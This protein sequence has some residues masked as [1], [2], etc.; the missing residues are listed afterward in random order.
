MKLRSPAVE[1]RNSK[2]RVCARSVADHRWYAVQGI[3]KTLDSI[4]GSRKRA[5]A[6]NMICMDLFARI[7]RDLNDNPGTS[8][9][10]LL[11]YVVN[12]NAP[13]SKA[14]DFRAALLRL[15]KYKALSL[16]SVRRAW[17]ANRLSPSKDVFNGKKSADE[18]GP[19]SRVILTQLQA[20]HLS[21][22]DHLMVIHKVKES[23]Y[24][25]SEP[26]TSVLNMAR[27][28]ARNYMP[29]G[30]RASLRGALV[31][32]GPGAQKPSV[33]GIRSARATA[34]HVE[35][36]KRH[37]GEIEYATMKLH[38][39]VGMKEKLFLVTGA[40]WGHGESSPGSS[41][42]LD[43]DLVS[44]HFRYL[45]CRE[46]EEDRSL[47]IAPDPLAAV[48]GPEEFSDLD[49]SYCDGEIRRPRGL[50]GLFVSTFAEPTSERL[51]TL[52]E[53]CRGRGSHGQREGRS[54]SETGQQELS[55][56][57]GDAR[58][59]PS[60]A[61]RSRT[62]ESAWLGSSAR[63]ASS[64]VASEPCATCS[65]ETKGCCPALRSCTRTSSASWRTTGE[66][67]SD[68]R[69]S[70]TCTGAASEAPSTWPSWVDSLSPTRNLNSFAL[71]LQKPRERS[72]ANAVRYVFETLCDTG[73]KRREETPTRAASSQKKKR[74]RRRDPGSGADGA[75]AMLGEPRKRVTVGMARM[76]K[77]Y[78]NGA[79]SRDQAAVDRR[80]GEPRSF[81]V[82]VRAAR[83]IVVGAARRNARGGSRAARL[84]RHGRGARRLHWD[85]AE[86][87]RQALDRCEMRI[88]VQDSEI[89]VRPLGAEEASDRPR[90]RLL[91]AR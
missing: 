31:K 43:G 85:T 32:D 7:L 54:D 64:T 3:T 5:R 72:S 38:A 13:E 30:P 47:L 84:S 78:V 90:V 88:D 21:P 68:Q 9:R 26:A 52:R 81:F 77:A 66:P 27:T 65:S 76:A 74:K 36:C 89:R 50:S 37:L 6:H 18:V 14:A 8:L 55:R 62:R 39:D 23:D 49:P 86:D 16:K 40:E 59:A 44:F 11:E 25:E 46:L 10:W 91:R 34:P 87:P 15:L 51:A 19:V 79:G 82:V 58:L 61:A 80:G 2:A 56:G 48:A 69:R 42:G 67:R 41:A 71:E 75:E 53:A 1:F 29:E 57:S 70:T 24:V 4:A 12:L 17:D 20:L 33:R 60:G 45:D 35:F 83:E 63:D 22:I 73:E 28:L